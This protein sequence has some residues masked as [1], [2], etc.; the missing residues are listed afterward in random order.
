MENLYCIET[1]TICE[2]ESI[3]L[4]CVSLRFYLAVTVIV[5]SVLDNREIPYLTITFN[6]ISVVTKRRHYLSSLIKVS[7]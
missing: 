4:K 6:Y 7:T 5:S 2:T 1:F 3:K